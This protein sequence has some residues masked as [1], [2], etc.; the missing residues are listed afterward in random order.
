M[1]ALPALITVTV[2][3][4]IVATAV[5]RLSYENAP[6]LLD[7]GSTRANGATPKLTSE[8]V[9]VAISCGGLYTNIVGGIG[10]TVNDASTVPI[11]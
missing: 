11:V 1:L 6:V 8:I 5:F 3:P 7:E 2:F 10:K 9:H 4:E